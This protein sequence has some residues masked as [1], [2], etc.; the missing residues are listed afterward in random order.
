MASPFNQGAP[1]AGVLLHNQTLGKLTSHFDVPSLLPFTSN[2][3]PTHMGTW[4]LFALAHKSQ[5]PY[6]VTNFVTG[7]VQNIKGNKFT[8]DLP[9]AADQ[10]TYIE[11]VYADD[12]S[13]IGYGTQPFKMLVSNGK[14]GGYGSHI[15]TD[16]RAPYVMQVTNV[17]RKGEKWLY[18]LRYDGNYLGQDSIP[19]PILQKGSP[20]YK[21]GATR[22]TEFGQEYDSWESGKAGKR[23]YLRFLTTAELQTHYHMTY[24]SCKFLD[25]QE[26]DGDWV[27]KALESVVTYY[28]VD[29]RIGNGIQY[30]EEF[31]RAG[32]K[33]NIN[34]E[35]MAMLADDISMRI[36]AKQASIFQFWHPGSTTLQ[37]GYDS[38]YIAPGIWHQLDYSGYKHTF[39]IESFSKEK[40]LAAWRDYRAGKTDPVMYGSEPIIR[41]RTGRG[42]RILLMKAFEK[43]VN[44]VATGLMDASKFRQV[45]GDNVSGLR[46]NLPYYTSIRIPGE[47]I[48]VIEEDPSM[49]PVE[50]NRFT[51]PIVNG[52][53]LSSYSMIIEDYDVSRNNIITLRSSTFNGGN[54][55]MIVLNGNMSHPLYERQYKGATVHAGK[56]LKT[57]FAAYFHMTPDTSIVKDPTAILKL[58]PRNPINGTLTL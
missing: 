24:E 46:I 25:G 48:L 4:E 42:G 57:G 29:Q 16:V 28:G 38:D 32:G 58:V 41:V 7:A 14:L 8:F 33:A 1:I 55:K 13:K 30:L 20:L 40:I 21:Y 15:S 44:S 39:N 52:Y 11:E 37:D 53:R 10:N 23:R 45:E 22:S 27:E 50:D 19:Q 9:V 2:S 5:L 43:E 54:M 51:N 26:F 35:S 31:D 56:S 6:M 3:L 12:M 47:G 18:T 36:L 17:E 49:D 34:H